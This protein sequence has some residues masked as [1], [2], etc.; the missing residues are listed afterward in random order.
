MEKNM[1]NIVFDVAVIGGGVVGASIFNAVAKSGYSCALIEKNTDVATGASKANSGIVHAG[2]DAKTGTLKARFNVEGNKML[3]EVCER[4]GVPLKKIGAYVLGNNVDL[5]KGL[6]KRGMDNGVQNMCFLGKN[7]LKKA[8][9]NV[10]TNINFGLFAE[11]TY[12]V[13]PYLLTI[14]LVEE[15]IV[16]GGQLFLEYKTKKVSK[17]NGVFVL[18]DG[19]KTIYAKQLV[20]SCGAGY[21][22]MAKLIGSETYPIVFRRGEYYILDNSEKDIVS[23]VIFP[24]PDAHSKG[25]LVTP[26]VD[27]NILV[28][29]T[30]YDSDDSTITTEDGL[31]EIR[32]KAN[33]L[34][35]NIDLSKAIRIFSGVR[36]VVG[37]DF[38]IEKSKKVAGVVNLAGICSPGLTSAPAIAKYVMGL[39]GQNYMPMLRQE[40]IKPYLLLRNLD[41]KKINQLIKKDH[42]YGKIVCKCERVSE[43]EIIDAINRPFRPTTTDAIKRRVRAGMGRCQGGFCL[44]KVVKILAKENGLKL[45]DIRKEN[46]NS[47][48]IVGDVKGGWNNEN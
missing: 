32:M 5:I 2:F 25:V 33:S 42:R 18:T 16:N 29:P 43:G 1:E 3:P 37:E 36:S 20:N 8:I 15:G 46:N 38:V 10:N 45:N 24:L 35:N 6:L 13:N 48:W 9:P 40:K 21:N 11:D 12:I 4:L 23:S 41:D 27:G 34:L 19:N 17:E 26:T 44:D 14:C 22:E 39:L 7:D 28:G 30:S 31:N 47:N